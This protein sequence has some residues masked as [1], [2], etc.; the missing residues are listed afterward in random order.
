LTDRDATAAAAQAPRLVAFEHHPPSSAASS[1]E[2]HASSDTP[3]N[4]LLFIGGLGDGLG[5]VPYAADLA[6]RLPPTWRLAEVLLRSSYGG[7]GVSSL[8]EDAAELADCVRHFRA[9]RPGAKIALLGHSTGCQDALHYLTGP[10]WVRRPGVQGALLQAPVSDR[11][12]LLL[13]LPP[14]AYER[15]VAAAR[16]LVARGAGEDM[17]PR[18]LTADFFGLWPC[19]ARRWLSLASPPPAHDGADDYFS[20]DLSDTRLARS[21]GRVPPSTPLAIVYGGAD[22]YVPP[23]V[24][25]EALVARWI[26]IAERNGA[27]IV[28]KASGVVPGATHSLKR[29]PPEVYEEVMRRMLV[30]IEHIGASEV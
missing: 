21:F 29:V 23:H 7:W 22:E 24:D 2:Q 11:E 26:A 1:S 15:A 5:T 18:A 27:R 8:D 3:P 16:E 6:R 4:T 17:L 30:F 20:S 10:Q 25:K 13:Q 9:L 12:A 19:S 14:G 28:L